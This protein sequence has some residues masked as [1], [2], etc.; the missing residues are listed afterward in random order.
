M[1][2]D[3]YLCDLKEGFKPA[4]TNPAIWTNQEN[5]L[6]EVSKH[7]PVSESAR[8]KGVS[9]IPDVWARPL[10]FK[11]AL[12]DSG[13]ELHDE[14]YDEWKGLISLIIL[15][16]DGRYEI[17]FKKFNIDSASQVLSN[18][19][20]KLSP[21]ELEIGRDGLVYKW[22]DFAVIKLKIGDQF[23]PVG[24]TSPATLVYTALDILKIQME[25]RHAGI[26]EESD[27][28]K[29]KVLAF[30]QKREKLFEQAG[31][32][33]KD[34]RLTEPKDPKLRSKIKSWLEWFSNGDNSM[35]SSALVHDETTDMLFKLFARWRNDDLGGV[36]AGTSAKVKYDEQV[37][38]NLTGNLSE[39]YHAISSPIISETSE[40]LPSDFYLTNLSS[41]GKRYILVSEDIFKMGGEV[42]YG[43]LKKES[44][45]NLFDSPEVSGS[46]LNNMT[47]APKVEWIKPEL[48]FFTEKL[49]MSSRKILFDDVATFN[50]AE[51]YILPFTSEILKCFTNKEIVEQLNP[52][53][54]E[55]G[56]GA[57]RF[58]IKLSVGDGRKARKVTISRLY[59]KSDFQNKKNDGVIENIADVPVLEMW[60][61][62]YS[63]QWMR[64]F[65][66]HSDSTI[67]SFEP[68]VREGALNIENSLIDGRH[69]IAE[70]SQFPDALACTI[71]G[72]KAGLILLDRSQKEVK[73]TGSTWN[74]GV[75]FGTS[76][77]NIYVKKGLSSA[78][79]PMKY[80]VK[81]WRLS[82]SID[83]ER[84]ISLYK[85]FLPPDMGQVELPFVSALRIY[86]HGVLKSPF[87]DFC[88]HF[89]DRPPEPDPRIISNMKWDDN[90]RTPFVD[91]LAL[92]VI[93]EAVKGGAQKLVLNASY[94][95]S[96]NTKNIVGFR[97]LWISA[98]NK[99]KCTLDVEVNPGEDK[100][101]TESV[102]AGKY[103]DMELGAR[104]ELHAICID[105]G[106]GTSDICIWSDGQ[107]KYQSSVRMAGNLISN[108][109]RKSAAL[110]HSFFYDIQEESSSDESV[111]SRILDNLNRNITNRNLNFSDTHFDSVL[112]YHLRRNGELV[113]RK[114]VDMKDVEAFDLL[115][116]ILLVEF[117]SIAFYGGM[118]IDAMRRDETIDL[119]ETILD[120][121]ICW[122]GGGSQ[123]IKWIDF[124]EDDK[125][126]IATTVF[127][128][129]IR[130][131]KIKNTKYRMTKDPKAEASYGLIV[132]DVSVQ[133][134][135]IRSG[136]N[137]VGEDLILK[138]EAGT[139]V[140]FFDE[141][142]PEHIKKFDA[143]NGHFGEKFHVF[144]KT[145]DLI[146]DDEGFTKVNRLFT[147]DEIEGNF[148]A[149]ISKMQ[150]EIDRE[151]GQKESALPFFI[152]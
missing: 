134:D 62:F 71:K 124:G 121:D 123:F 74:V 34:G 111:K 12:F 66:Y 10:F 89:I 144:I 145:L 1:P 131:F 142:M 2:H 132:D 30:T 120:A 116:T 6:R 148:R 101:Y 122:G 3:F 57:V 75:D 70:I 128:K 135:K 7:I 118:V 73:S 54:K 59:Q 35:L 32:E 84:K 55:E 68:I 103:F 112:N 126:T 37:C 151:D 115:Q 49:L 85:Y 138:D 136:K 77:T 125:A 87:R 97:Q 8:A 21:K 25:E 5:I 127:N 63:P 102:A 114:M 28:W 86:Q 13:N 76:N 72:E 108:C 24:A 119:P 4:G 129:I 107:I 18:A 96:F 51:N 56:N 143:K 109:F 53:F 98:R 150:K 117:G 44:V 106:G 104:K 15:S 38:P 105:V 52:T 90:F 99:T 42:V 139:M 61:D 95:L 141:I 64:Y 82:N 40:L 41:D 113:K 140:N 100:E 19:L 31:I 78:L 152:M 147:L 130:S 48:F 133:K 146:L 11:T 43:A 22:L 81:S 29:E 27:E 58:S 17:E 79:E 65:I 88:V 33:L 39:I 20:I 26:E 50:N 16:R 83:H 149:R 60:P 47:L 110:R 137:I 69:I 80:C 46:N 93:A 92:L 36:S 14:I 23:F 67:F 45:R 94:P 91:H 9:S